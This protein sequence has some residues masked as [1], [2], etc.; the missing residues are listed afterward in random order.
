MASTADAALGGA[1]AHAR[2]AR[3]PQDIA[4][5]SGCLAL[6]VSAE[7]VFILFGLV[8]GTVTGLLAVAALVTIG[9]L[10]RE[11]LRGRAAIALAVVPL[12]RVLSIAIP[13]LLVPSWLWYADEC[14]V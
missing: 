14:I 9:T 4:A 1:R 2:R 5:I 7:V 10:A 3:T 11:H 6:V 12:L 8:A 13:S